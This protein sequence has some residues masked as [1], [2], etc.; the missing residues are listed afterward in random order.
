MRCS[1][2]TGRI[3]ISTRRVRVSNQT[4]AIAQAT[5]TMLDWHGV[6]YM[7][8]AHVAVRTIALEEVVNS[9]TPKRIHNYHT[10]A[11]ISGQAIALS[12]FI[13]KPLCG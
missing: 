2:T 7:L 12:R 8:H 6:D 13:F 1:I 5:V 10:H 9:S 11:A 4:S 3:F